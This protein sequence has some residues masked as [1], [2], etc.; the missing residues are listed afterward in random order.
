MVVPS[1]RMLCGR[2]SGG[3]SEEST[4]SFLRFEQYSKQEIKHNEKAN[5]DYQFLNFHSCC[6]FFRLLCPLSKPEDAG[7]MRLRN[8][9]VFLLDVNQIIILFRNF[10][11]VGNVI[12]PLRDLHLNHNY[13]ADVCAFGLILAC[14][15]FNRPVT[16]S[17]KMSFD[18]S[19]ICPVIRGSPYLC[20][21]IVLSFHI[22][23]RSIYI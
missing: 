7:S 22:F 2:F 14:S 6:L 12:S 21:Q 1:S 8:V 3:V 23:Q 4:A 17:L 15:S 18:M 9:G 16:P 13:N 20:R 10:V 11:A 19:N 5:R